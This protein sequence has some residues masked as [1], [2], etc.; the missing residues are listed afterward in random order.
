[1]DGILS[2]IKQLIQ[3]ATDFFQRALKA[4]DEFFKWVQDAFDYFGELLPV[5]PEY[6]FHRMTS[7][8]VKFFEWL[9]VP[10]FFVTAGN[11]FQGIPPSVVY[12]ANA[13]QIGPGVTMVLGAY[14]LRFILRRIPIIG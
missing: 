12:F 14:L 2:A 10:D 9:P 1:M 7:A 4:I 13:F 6:V 11:A 8:V 5:L 3:T